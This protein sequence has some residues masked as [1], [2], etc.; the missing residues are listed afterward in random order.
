M[1][2]PYGCSRPPVPPRVPSQSILEQTS[3]PEIDSE[4]FFESTLPSR[5]MAIPGTTVNHI[6]P[7]LPPVRYNVD[8]ERGIDIAWILQNE[9]LLRDK[10]RLA[11]I[12]P[13]SSLFGQYSH[14]QSARLTD[15]DMPMD[16][17]FDQPTCNSE[18]GSHTSQIDDVIS[19]RRYSASSSQSSQSRLNQR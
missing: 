13:G 16:W 9:S 14:P 5:S 2:V 6:P 10:S 18:K 19:T 12:K 17:E 4:V 7:P 11:P 3:S 15:D 8:L 1:D